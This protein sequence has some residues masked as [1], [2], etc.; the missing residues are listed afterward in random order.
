MFETLFGDGGSVADRQAALK[1]RASLLDSVN[2]EIRRLQKTL[3]PSDRAKITE[4]LDK[5]F[6]EAVE[7]AQ[8]GDDR[9]KLHLRRLAIRDPES[10]LGQTAAT[11]LAALAE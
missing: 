11:V 7:L 10:D 5:A 8:G 3:G 4:Y 6:D 2:E 9:A 1:R